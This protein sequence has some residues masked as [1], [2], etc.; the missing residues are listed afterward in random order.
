M[1]P[2]TVTEFR[3]AFMER[4]NKIC[5]D[6]L[7]RFPLIDAD[8]FDNLVA[9]IENHILE[10]IDLR[11]EVVD[12]IDGKDVTIEIDEDVVH[13]CLYGRC[14]DDPVTEKQDRRE[15]TILY[16]KTYFGGGKVSWLRFKYHNG[17][18]C[19]YKRYV[20]VYNLGL[21]KEIKTASAS[22]VDE[23]GGF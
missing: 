15:A 10:R 3:A 18:G 14:N 13:G 1:P 19:V 9:H 12:V 5:S 2:R 22:E 23:W 17:T 11:T 20:F 6:H 7:V 16:L 4:Y 21:P 8:P